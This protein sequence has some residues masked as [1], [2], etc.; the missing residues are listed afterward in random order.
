MTNE[1][2]RIAELQSHRVHCTADKNSVS[3]CNPKPYSHLFAVPLPLLVAQQEF[4]NHPWQDL[5][6]LQLP[7]RGFRLTTHATSDTQLLPAPQDVR[8]VL[9]CPLSKDSNPITS[10][11]K[12][13][14]VLSTDC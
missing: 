7:P 3:R 9:G 11:Q 8:N 1:G 2:E 13:S 4:P 6:K 12:R 5:A 10:F 14:S